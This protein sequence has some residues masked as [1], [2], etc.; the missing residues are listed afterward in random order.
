[1]KKVLVT[2]TFD[3]IHSGHRRLLHD[4]RLKGDFLT[5][6]IARD[7]TVRR[8][9][10]YAPYF[11]QAE[12][13]KNMRALRLADRI[14]PGGSGDKLS[15]IESERPDIIC[16]GYDQFAFTDDLKKKLATRGLH[17][18]I[19]RARRFSA[20]GFRTG[21]LHAAGLV[22]LH[23]LNPSIKIEP[24]YAT[25]RNFTGKQLYQNRII[26]GRSHVATMVKKAQAILQRQGYG[27]KIWDCYRPLS[28]QKI[29]W[30]HLPDERYVGNPKKGPVHTRGTGVDCTLVDRNGRELPMPTHYDEFSDRAHRQHPAHPTPRERHALILEKAMIRAGFEA[31]PTEWWHFSDPH[32]KKYPVLDIAI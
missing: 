28:A 16:L 18:R 23:R 17:P 25:A 8:V 1:M 19:T 30:R 9:K 31:L 12:R 32:W 27:L 5:V 29:L 21:G 11:T 3:L 26:L 10:G 24:R 4:A 22:A 13:V 2:G 6:V 7:V 15:V 20:G 14:I